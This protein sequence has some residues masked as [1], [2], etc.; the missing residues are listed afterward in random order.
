M[1]N[2][3]TSSGTVFI[4]NIPLNDIFQYLLHC[5]TRNHFLEML[6]FLTSPTNLT[7]HQLIHHIIIVILTLTTPNIL[8]VILL[9]LSLCYIQFLLIQFTVHREV[10]TFSSR[11]LALKLLLSKAYSVGYQYIMF[12]AS[13]PYPVILPRN[14]LICLTTCL[15]K[16]LY[17]G[18]EVEI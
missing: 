18:I 10:Y 5:L 9:P 2:F 13:L 14:I 11:L 6:L 16:L 1:I 7:L 17:H 8:Q 4:P 15:R 12:Y 3:S